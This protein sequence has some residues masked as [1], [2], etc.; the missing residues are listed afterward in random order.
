MI[1][2]S[3][4]VAYQ[5]V[6]CTDHLLLSP[7]CAFQQHTSW[8]KYAGSLM[9]EFSSICLSGRCTQILGIRPSIRAE[10]RKRG[11]A[12]ERWLLDLD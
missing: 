8:Y 11:N 1:E 3:A 10:R 6:M 5:S 9:A 7:A 12:H 2:L 4:P